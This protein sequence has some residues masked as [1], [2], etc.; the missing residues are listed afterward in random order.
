MT[1]SDA[2]TATLQ[3]LGIISIL[4]MLGAFLRAKI[5]LFQN[6]YLPSCVIGGFIGLILGPNALNIIPFSE[7]T[8]AVASA[9]PNLLI[10]PVLAA[11]P[12]GLKLFGNKTKVTDTL[13]KS[14]DVL[15]ISFLVAGF[16]ML[17]LAVGCGIT[18]VCK[19]L[20]AN[21]FDGMGLE[22]GAGF[23]GGH[24]TAASIGSSFQELG[25]PNWEA[26]LGGGMTTA[27]V[28]VIS[29]I[30]IGTVLINY[31]ARRGYTTQI[32]SAAETPV[33]MRVGL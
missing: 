21:T 16:L 2:L 12:M 7:N 32:K 27:T 29:G 18:L 9:L 23:A 17:Q 31:A 10:I 5:P 25:N 11:T 30:V 28:G 4:L 6:L 14:N 26:A 13:R 15:I 3:S 22:M 19:A 33:E 20:G 1:I 8:M 24:G